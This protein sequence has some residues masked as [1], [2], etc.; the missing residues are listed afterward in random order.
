M[1]TNKESIC[2]KITLTNEFN[3]YIT[4]FGPTLAA[5]TPM[6]TYYLYY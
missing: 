6:V 3:K 2:D 4:N 5:K 1:M